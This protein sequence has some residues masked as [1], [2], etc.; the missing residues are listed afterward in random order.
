MNQIIIIIILLLII[1]NNYIK[2]QTRCLNINCIKENIY[3]D[4]Y[5]T[6]D[7]IMFS[8]Q[9]PSYYYGTNGINMDVSI[10]KNSLLNFVKHNM[11]YFTHCGIIIIIKKIPYVL[12]IVAEPQ[13][14][15]YYKK[16]TLGSLALVSIYEIEK[17]R[18][19]IYKYKYIGNT[20]PTPHLLLDYMYKINPLLDGNL[21]S[22]TLHRF[23]NYTGNKGLCCDVIR[24]VLLYY[25]IISD[26]NNWDI[27]NIIEFINKSSLYIKTP[28]LLKN[29]WYDCANTIA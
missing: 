14:D 9:S 18:G 15:N 27:Q 8:F 7:I 25:N 26:N 11:Y 13:Y 10:L 2:N 5:N 22:I 12:H 29:G 17:Y 6:G 20:L 21:F 3:N 19:Y 23:F 4:N 16:N 24:M 28:T 1:H